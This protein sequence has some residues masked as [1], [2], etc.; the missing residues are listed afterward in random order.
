MA[1][2]S[3]W[4]PSRTTSRRGTSSLPASPGRCSPASASGPSRSPCRSSPRS[5]SPTRTSPRTGPSS[6]LRAYGS[7][8]RASDVVTFTVSSGTLPMAAVTVTAPAFQVAEV[9]LPQLSVG[10]HRL[11]VVAR[12]GSSGSRHRDALERTFDVV[13]R[14]AVASVVTRHPLDSSI[15]VPAGDG[16]TTLTLTD[17]GRGRVLPVLE[18]LAGADPMRGDAALA[19][20]IAA[21]TLKDAFGAS[22]HEAAL[23]LDL[24]PF[25]DG[26]GVRVDAARRRLPGAA[27]AGDA[28]PRSAAGRSLRR[29]GVGRADD[30]RGADVASRR[31]RRRRVRLR[32]RGRDR[33]RA[34]RPHRPRAGRARDRGAGRRGRCPRGGDRGRR[35]APVWRAQRA[36]GPRRARQPRGV[37]RAD[38]SPGDRRRVARRSG[39]RRDG[40]L[41]RRQPAA[42]DHPRPR[43]RPRRPGLGQ[44]GPGRRCRGEAHD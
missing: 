27:R 11:R 1:G 31:A 12:E 32:D 5:R 43:A 9:A 26:H 13:E 41:S 16:L 15:P 35:A 22:G 20:G 29:R 25:R 8:L 4:S 38:R 33:R 14:R 37:G 2:L 42:P 10:T 19:A 7:A 39:R 3:S 36:V 44:P 23:D 24:S 17:G 21:R 28:R 6:G 40:R 34:A 18:E 30:A